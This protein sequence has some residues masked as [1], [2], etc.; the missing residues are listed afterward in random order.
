MTLADLMERAFAE[1]W[2]PSSR[3]RP[4]KS[5]VGRYAQLLG[6]KSLNTCPLETAI[7]PQATI[8]ALVETHAKP[9]LLPESIANQW[10]SVWNLLEMAAVQGCVSALP[11]TDEHNWRARGNMHQASRV[12]QHRWDGL[13]LGRYGLIDWP[14][15]LAHETY[16]YVAWCQKPLARGRPARIQKVDSTAGNVYTTVGQVAGY[17]VQQRGISREAL[18]LAALC[19]PTLLEDF[20]WWWIGERRQL[21]TETILSKLGMMHTI[22]R[23]WLK[24][25]DTTAKITAI[26]HRLKEEA[27]VV[28]VVDKQK[29][30]LPLEELDRI[31]RSTNPRSE[32]RMRLNKMVRYVER[33]LSDPVGHPLPPSWQPDYIP[34]RPYPRGGGKN[35][36]FRILAVWAGVELVIRLL[37][38]RPLRI[39]NICHL[40]FRHLMTRNGELH[41]VI[42]KAELKNAKYF[43]EAEW[44]ERF[45]KRLADRWREY[46]EI[47]RP[48]LDTNKSPY[49]FLNRYGKP[50]IPTILTNLIG[51][52]TWRYTQDRDGG[53]V[54]VPAHMIRTIWTSEMLHAGLHVLVV[55][56]ILGDSLSVLERHYTRYERRPPSEFALNLAKEIEQGID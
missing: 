26:F 14:I 22:A 20:V 41:I 18:S 44:S 55:R 23:H 47:W 50:Y 7:R 51:K 32:S 21:S 15:D 48:R 24:D 13:A 36:T 30:W 16:N 42:P 8:Q 3:Y 9:G 35:G 49:V 12:H 5:A 39:G 31:A 1:Q 52:T 54:A 43:P 17:A 37:V 25:A 45:P 56:R 27:P 40:E 29:R 2:F 19:E 11:T 33:H 10:R 53:P 4:M 38:H 46:Q 28:K 6:Y 34:P